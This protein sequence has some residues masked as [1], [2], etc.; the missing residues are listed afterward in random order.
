MKFEHLIEIN[1][2]LNPLIDSLTREQLWRGLVLHAESPKLFVPH[3]DECD[4]VEREP[5]SGDLERSIRVEPLEARVP[6]TPHRHCLGGQRREPRDR[7][8]VA[9]LG[10]CVG[11]EK[12]QDVTGRRSRS[13]IAGGGETKTLI[14]LP[15]KS[16]AVRHARLLVRTVVDDDDLE[17]VC[18]MRLPGQG[19]ER[20]IELGLL[21]EVHHHDRDRGR[22]SG[23]DSVELI[24]LVA[25]DARAEERPARAGHERSV[26][27]HHV[28][29][30]HHAR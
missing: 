14:G 28:T 8:D 13:E 27:G 20:A 1:D 3:L 6:A 21:L 17:P 9:R 12:A 22:H 10:G 25:P 26:D 7:L 19:G 2:P 16:G 29:P 30:S 15:Q 18:R 4:I 24:P 5:G 23:H 11:V